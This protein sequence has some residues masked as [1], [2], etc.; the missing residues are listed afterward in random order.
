MPIRPARPRLTEKE[1]TL[2]R[3]VAIEHQVNTT[4]R[5]LS[6]LRESFNPAVAEDA[7]AC[8]AGW[9]E[10]RSLIVKLWNAEKERQED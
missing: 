1:A 8:W 3:T 9:R 2:L 10:Y 6:R 5:L 7:K 4:I